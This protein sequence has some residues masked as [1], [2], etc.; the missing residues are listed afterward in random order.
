MIDLGRA[1][2]ARVEPSA[3]WLRRHAKVLVAGAVLLAVAI[4]VC[5]LVGLSPWLPPVLVLLAFVALRP[6]P[7]LG[8]AIVVLSVPLGLWAIGVEDVVGSAFGGRDYMLNISAVAVVFLHVARTA[9]GWRPSR[10][11][12]IAAGVAAAVLAVSALIGFAHHGVPQ[13]LIG[14][15]YVVFPVVFLAAVVARPARD[16]ARL[17]GL[18]AWVMVANA[19][20]AVGEFIVGPARLA[21]WGLD[22][23]NAIRYINGNFRAPGLTDFNA[24]LGMLAGAF[25]L[26]YLGLWLTRGS[27][28]RRW[29]WHA[30]AVAAALCLAL[31]TSRSG[32]VLLVAGLVVAVVLNRSGGAAARRRSRLLGLAVLAA[33]AV[34]FVAV[35]ATGGSSLLQR[36][37][38]WGSLLRGH[39]PAYGLGVGAVGAA[40]NSRV[41]AG[42]QV[43]V[44]NYVISVALQFGPVVAAVLVVL[45]VAA[46]VRLCRRS[47]DR[48]TYVL[49]IAVVAGLAASF[50]LI[51]SWEYDSA[52]ACLAV[53]VAH[54]LRD[55]PENAP[56]G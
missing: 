31:S 54:G 37:D 33:V 7:G 44:D 29:S 38:V 39:V 17:V 19:L 45:I 21:A 46:L 55:A 42:S 16:I 9:V 35:G 2:E 14:V 6:L 23:G 24:E 36:L 41:A 32:A 8:Y 49:Y 1:V 25:L 26:G 50:L 52:M 4:V 27:R 51:E 12:A 56:Y 10:A 48:P 3:A 28:P 13:T 43:F 5:L 18:F 53:F 22:N 30:G 40:S 34:G 47:V 20:A 15:R 11:Q